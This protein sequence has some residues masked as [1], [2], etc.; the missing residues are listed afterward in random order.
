MSYPYWARSST[1]GSPANVVKFSTR[2]LPKQGN[3][4]TIYAEEYQI[5]GDIV[6]ANMSI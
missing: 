3:M 2:C 5:R 1:K 4:A 6:F